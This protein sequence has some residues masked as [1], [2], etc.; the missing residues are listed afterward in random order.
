MTDSEKVVRRNPHGDFGA[1]Q[2]SRPQWKED[3]KLEFTQTRDP[4]WTKGD[5]AIETFDEKHVDID[6]WE[7]GRPSVYNY[8][9]LIS[10]IIPRPIGFVSTVSPQGN[11]NLAPFSYF[12]LV[13]HDPPSFI[14]SF[15]GGFKDSLR[16]LLE[17]NECTIS[18]ISEHF[19]E[20]AN[21]TSVNSP[22]G[23]SEWELS[24]LTPSPSVTVK[25][26]R[27]KESVFGIEGKLALTHGFFSKGDPD[28]KTGTLTLIEGTMFWCRGDALNKEKNLVDPGILRPVARLGGITYGR[29][30]NAFELLRPDWEEFKG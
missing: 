11:R 14:V 4:T 1:V 21:S 6:P 7:Q 15:V 13:N 8:K 24:G 29:I 22:F 3:S 12:Q 19:V 16:N 18:I 23:V 30:M 20:A 27:V 17:T 2:A 26:P 28:K 9:L 10:A 5:G 25:P